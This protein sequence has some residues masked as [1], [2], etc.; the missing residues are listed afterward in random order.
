[1][2]CEKCQSK[3]DKVICPDVWKD[4]ARN[5]TESGGR[6]MSENKLLDKSKRKF[7][8]YG[9]KGSLYGGK[10]KECKAQLHQQGIYCQ[11]CA[12][13]KGECSMCGVKILDIKLYKQSTY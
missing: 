6:K 10:C 11:R 3:L 5:T 7:Q 8:P 12:Y 13:Q 2:V 9:G 4:G 1:M